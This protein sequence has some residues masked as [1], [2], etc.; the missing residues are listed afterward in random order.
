MLL[1]E[2]VKH[3]EAAEKTVVEERSA[4]QAAKYDLRT[5]QVSAAGLTQ[6]LSY[7]LS[8][9]RL[10]RMRFGRLPMRSKLWSGS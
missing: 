5:A 6:E 7:H 3:L 9:R 10:L 8:E 2:L 1:V 4:H